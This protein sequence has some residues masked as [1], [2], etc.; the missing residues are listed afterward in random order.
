MPKLN[1]TQNVILVHAAR[2][3]GGAVHPLPKSLKADAK[4][5]ERA[6]KGL[7]RRPGGA[8]VP[9]MMESSSWQAHSVR[10]FISGTL[11]AK[12]GLTIESAVE[13]DRGRVYR[14]TES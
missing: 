5:V 3:S 9:E 8:T 6:L 12:L 1:D 7:L 2:R 10:G 13:G 4:A 11:K 14:V